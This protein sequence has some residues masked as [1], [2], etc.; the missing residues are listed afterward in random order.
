MN[1]CLAQ[2]TADT[3]RDRT[4]GLT[5][6]TDV[7]MLSWYY[8]LRSPVLFFGSAIS[9]FRPPMTWPSSSLPSSG[10]FF[11]YIYICLT[12]SCPSG[13]FSLG[14]FGSLSPRKASC[15]SVSIILRTLTWTT[16]FLTCVRDYSYA[17]VYTR[18]LGTPIASQ[19]NIFDSENSHKFP[20][21]S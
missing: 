20:L 7:S 9:T 8:L 16:G 21:C 13:N 12:L 2:S 11:I 14:K 10:V 15:N 6:F 4:L 17:R 5:S 19:H 18:G 1:E 3:T